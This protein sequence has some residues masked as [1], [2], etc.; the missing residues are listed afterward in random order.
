MNLVSNVK[1]RIERYK[2]N[3]LFNRLFTVLSIDI[4]VKV[5]GIILLPVYLRL[6]TQEEYGL[7][8]YLLSIIM[9]FSIV[10]N[11]GLYI[12]LSKFYHDYQDAEKRGILLFTISL[13]LVIM[14]ASVILPVYFF[15]WDYD[16]IRILFKNPVDYKEYRGAVLIAIIVSVFS[17][18]LTNFFFTSEKIKYLK[19]YNIFRIICINVITIFFLYLFRNID[20][21]RIRLQTTYFTELILF[22]I[23]CYFYIKEVSFKFNKKEAKIGLKLALPVMVS[24][25]FGIGINFSD[26]FFLEKYSSFKDLSYYYLAISLA[27]AIPLIFASLQNAW[28]PLFLKEK[29]IQKNIITTNKLMRRLVI[30]F[31]VLSVLIIVSFK[32]ILEL[33]IIQAKYNEAIA[34]LPL[35]LISQIISSLVSLHTNYLVYFERTYIVSITGFIVCIISLGLSLLLIPRYKVYGAATV[36]LISNVVYLGLYYFIIKAATKKYLRLKTN[37]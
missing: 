30:G 28:L 35:L 27:S 7:Y 6:M 19:R 21:V 25:I 13:L 22:L 2:K 24:A 8:G 33:G 20:S 29:D 11:F 26:K 1:A 14:L 17:F 32:I 31:L 16:L 23:F 3:V 4:L 15:E 18:M 5:S 36:S 12:P 34:I 9:T 37:I 10:L